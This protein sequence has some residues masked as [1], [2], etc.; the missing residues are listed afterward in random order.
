[1]L[2]SSGITNLSLAEALRSIVNAPIKIAFIPT[3]ANN[4]RGNKEW[5]EEDILNCKKIGSVDIVD[6]S[7]MKKEEWL[8]LLEKA[9][10]IFM[11]GGDTSYLMNW[12]TKSGLIKELPELLKKRVYV[13]ISAGTIVLSKRLSA[14]REFLYGD[15]TKKPLSGLGYVNFYVRPHLNSKNFPKVRDIFLKKLV[16]KFDGDLYALDDDSAIIYDSGKIK[17]V[18]EGKWIKYAPIRN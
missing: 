2:T 15:E 3:A 7:V 12:I 18:S 16:S 5:L 9:N 11:G 13:G 14:S 4:K 8:P 17:V 1:M 6:I 10:V